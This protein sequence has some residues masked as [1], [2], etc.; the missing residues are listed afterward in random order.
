MRDTAYGATHKLGLV[1]LVLAVLPAMAVV[2]TGVGS[3]VMGAG[4]LLTMACAS[5]M[6]SA[7]WRYV[8]QEH[9]VYA[10]IL[11]AATVASMVQMIASVALPPVSKSL[12]LYLPLVS[13]SCALTSFWEASDQDHELEDSLVR[14]VR[15]GTTYLLTL[16]V[17]GCIR[18]VLGVGSIFGFSLGDG[19]SPMYLMATAPG[20]FILAGVLL[21]I[22]RALLPGRMK[23]GDV[24]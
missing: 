22:V 12:G 20:G 16:T 5:L 7:V 4:V 14:A 9:R 2:S 24:A 3:L 10:Y 18:E 11:F 23:G 13:F 6:L 1:P 19:F 21:A 15:N 17:T 8:R